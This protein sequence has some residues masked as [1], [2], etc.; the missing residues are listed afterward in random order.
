MAAP[1]VDYSKVKLNINIDTCFRMA[2]ARW[3]NYFGGLNHFVIIY[4]SSYLIAPKLACTHFHGPFI[5]AFVIKILN[6]FILMYTID[7][8]NTTQTQSWVVMIQCHS[9]GCPWVASNI[10]KTISFKK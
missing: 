7:Y 2:L 5:P 1:K 6:V 4:Y 8:E 9:Q 10:Y 3:V